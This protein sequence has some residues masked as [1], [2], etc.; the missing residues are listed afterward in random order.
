MGQRRVIGSTRTSEQ[1][2]ERSPSRIEKCQ[3]HERVEKGR[4]RGHRSSF[5]RLTFRKWM[6]LERRRDFRF[7]FLLFFLKITKSNKLTLRSCLF[8]QAGVPHTPQHRPATTIHPNPMRIFQFPTLHL[9]FFLQSVFVCSRE[10][11]RAEDDT[12]DLPSTILRPSET[13]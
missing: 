5:C 12:R 8:R 4:S 10:G 7:A 6:K 3:S 2:R 1:K 11:F 9:L 13:I